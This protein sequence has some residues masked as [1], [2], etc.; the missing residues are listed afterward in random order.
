MNRQASVFRSSVLIVACLAMLG[1]VL[2]GPLAAVPPSGFV[3]MA[4]FP[5][6]LCHTGSPD[7]PD[8]AGHAAD[9]DTC[10]LCQMVQS[11]VP[12][13][14]AAPVLLGPPASSGPGLVAASRAL[15]AA[16]VARGPR[17]RAPPRVA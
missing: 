3:L 6:P 2:R 13:L 11:A 14:P 5:A 12:I 1:L 16:P 4:G 17:A 8:P 10:L 7:R 15:Q 9:C